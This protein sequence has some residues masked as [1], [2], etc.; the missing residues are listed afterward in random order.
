MFRNDWKYVP[1]KLEKGAI[2]KSNIMC[3]AIKLNII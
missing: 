2:N 1:Y 3:L